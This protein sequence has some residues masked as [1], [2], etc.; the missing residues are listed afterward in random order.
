MNHSAQSA[1]HETGERARHPP[2]MG[3]AQPGA[4][5]GVFTPGLVAFG[6]DS[7]SGAFI[8][9]L[10]HSVLVAPVALGSLSETPPLSRQ[11]REPPN[12]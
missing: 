11:H 6:I 1:S 9:P 4:A 10:A 7:S 3:R 12:V 5:T 8:Y 2:G